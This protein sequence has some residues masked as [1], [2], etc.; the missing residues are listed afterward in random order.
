V[1]FDTIPLLPEDLFTQLSA[2]QA[3]AQRVHPPAVEPAVL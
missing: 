2:L 3:P 1:E